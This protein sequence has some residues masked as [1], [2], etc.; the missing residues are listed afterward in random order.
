MKKKRTS[1]WIQISTWAIV[2]ILISPIIYMVLMSFRLP[3]E[4]FSISPIFRPTLSNY[5]NMLDRIRLG[6]YFINSIIVATSSTA[7]SLLLGTVAAY[8]LVRFAYVGRKF[9]LFLLLF[10][11]MM[12]P[13]G[14]IVALFL[15]M[16][17]WGLTESYMAILLIYTVF[18]TPFVAWMMRG[19]FMGVS[20][21]LEFS[22]MLDGCSR[23]GA[24][25]RITIPLC[26][27]G[28]VATAIFTF[29]LSWNEFFFAL[30]FTAGSTKTVPVVIPELIADTGIYWGEIGSAGTLALLPILVFTWFV[31]KHLIR[32]LT[33]G[34][35]KG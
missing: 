26:A 15:M 35:L 10:V 16:R 22:A 2:I 18:N 4:V 30:I 12:P 14:I 5:A 20:E 13:I 28:M 9:L 6:K 24:F 33:F 31:Q 3:L 23:L 11:R 34:A 25:V 27:S 32:G 21:E 8:S 7:M 17:G 19:F 1:M 29:T